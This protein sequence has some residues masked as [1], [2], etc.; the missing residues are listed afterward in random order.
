[1]IFGTLMHR[2]TKI[3]CTMG[4]AVQ[5][6]EAIQ[7]LIHAGMNVARLNFSHGTYEDHGRF[8]QLLKEARA[9]RGVP[10]AIML[11]TKG[12]EIR[13]GSK[14]QER[15]FRAGERIALGQ[16]PDQIPV[17]PAEVLAY[18]KP[19][20]KVLFDDGYLIAHVVS[21]HEGSVE[22]E[23]FNE[24]V[25][26]PNKSMNLPGTRVPLPALTD[27]DVED[28]RFGVENGIDLVA[29]SFVRSAE[30]V[31]AIRD[32]LHRLGA[33]DVQII[34]K[35]E[36]A[37]GIQNFDEIVQVADGIMVARGDLGVELPIA[38]V[39][40]LQKM[41]IR[42]CYQAGKPVVTATQMLES[43]IHHPRPTRAEV[44]D[45]ANAIY[46]STSAVMLSGETAMGSYPV[47]AVRVMQAVIE[48]TERDLNFTDIGG[49]V[50]QAM[51]HETPSAVA[52]AAVKTACASGARAIF[53]FTRTGGT[54]RLLSRLRPSL[55]ILAFVPEQRRFHQM[56]LLWG[57]HPFLAPAD[58]HLGSAFRAAAEQALASHAV[59]FGDLVV[60][61]AGAPFGV[62]GTTNSMIVETIG[63]VL[64]RGKGVGTSGTGLL[65]RWH[66]GVDQLDGAI[67]WVQ[68]WTAAI[69]ED[70]LRAAAIIY[71]NALPDPH[72]ERSWLEWGQQHH[73][74]IVVR[75]NC[76]EVLLEE[77]QLMT[78]EGRRGLVLPGEVLP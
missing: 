25:L 28:L 40:R 58:D 63:R 18:L 53:A 19:E 1:M 34:A 14:W 11:D 8:I 54:A 16:A 22:I 73:K 47:E 5:S 41:M 13:V 77:G 68:D 15:A 59:R 52:L 67:L 30:H 46:D 10:L 23:F 17:R 37:E 3:I 76:P 48:E 61:T 31:M 38:Q 20:M 71:T 57:V 55:P 35:I 62:V 69:A 27:Q 29:A 70:A 51:Q 44:S 6:A 60:V 74:T 32:C 66:A 56:A 33:P 2:R 39:P 42:K 45:V 12:P 36:N 9:A 78:V 24:G 26:K 4:P 7:D 43:M 75:T 49:P 72:K 21:A 65:K 50:G 64:L